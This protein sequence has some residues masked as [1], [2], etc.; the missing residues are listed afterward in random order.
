[1]KTQQLQ[2]AVEAFDFD[3]N[4][5]EHIPNIGRLIADKQVVVVKQRVTQAR[6]YDILD[7][8]GGPGMSPVIGAIGT[9][10]LKGKH[11][12][13]IRN[14][15]IR[16]GSTIDP[17]HRNRMQSVTF[18]KDHK[19]RALG[20]FTNGKLGWHNDQ[21]SFESA[22]RVVGLASVEG[23]EGSQT[24]FLSSAECYADLNH[25]DKT[26]V[27]EL[28]CVNSWN[29]NYNKDGALQNFAGELIEEQHAIMRYNGCPLDG[30]MAPLRAE[31]ASGV[32]GIHFPGSLFGHFYGMTPK[33]S[34]KFI[35]HIWSLMNQPK[36]IYTHNW[37]NG[38]VCYMDQAITLH[39][40]PTSVD[41]GNTR[42]MW[43]C[44]GYLDKLYPN[45]GP[46]TMT[47]NVDG[48][49]I[50]WDELFKRVDEVRLAEYNSAK[51]SKIFKRMP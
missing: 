40:R 12:N 14:T 2:N 27:D 6:H 10:K 38:E 29:M 4:S 35:K 5:D 20:I 50:T 43:R 1:V 3:I 51:W 19:G 39:A 17:R 47:I 42:K 21:P 32:P 33:E 7:S 8:W 13:A 34:E 22:Q 41:E 31:T 28:L 16:I 37:K 9:G 25:E 26:Q 44:S 30:L 45:K 36:H 48:K 46:M 15:I 18:Q 11:W 23:S 24:T 49:N